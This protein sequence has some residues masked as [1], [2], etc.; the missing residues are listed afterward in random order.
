MKRPYDLPI[1]F[2]LVFKWEINLKI[3]FRKKVTKIALVDSFTFST[4]RGICK[5]Q[6]DISPSKA[7]ISYCRLGLS[8]GHPLGLGRRLVE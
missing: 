1:V 2:K 5:A 8:C 4:G 6:F 3:T 7:Y